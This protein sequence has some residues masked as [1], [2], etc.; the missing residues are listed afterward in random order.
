MH[1]RR[2]LVTALS[3]LAGLPL[4]AAAGP[5]RLPPACAWIVGTWH[6]DVDQTL[7][8]F[9]FQGQSPTPEMR[10]RMARM[11]GR[12]THTVTPT[13]FTV[14][15]TFDGQTTR[16]SWD[17]EVDR[18]S[19][20]SVSLVFAAAGVPGLTLFRKDDAYFIRTG[21]NFEYFKKAK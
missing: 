21:S 3:A 18:F 1:H 2:T 8:N 10:A 14:D 5:R 6:S 17:Y 15:E 20:S 19:A 13:R 4:L 11:V 16:Q 7:A 12:L 9:S